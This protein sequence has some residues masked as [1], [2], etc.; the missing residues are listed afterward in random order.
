MFRK[1]A[2]PRSRPGMPLSRHLPGPIESSRN[3]HVRHLSG[4]RTHQIDNIGVDAP[5]VLARA[6]LAHPQSRMILAC[7]A[8][9]EIETVVLHAHDDLLDQHA[10]DAFTG[11][12]GR[13]FRMPG[14]LDV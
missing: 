14:A 8:D 4:H 9:D 13:P 3:A 1:P 12:D 2:T 11:G 10:D 6:V 7:T 5:A